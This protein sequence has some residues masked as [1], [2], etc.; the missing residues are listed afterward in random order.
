[1]STRESAHPLAEHARQNRTAPPR[2]HRRN[3]ARRAVVGGAL[4]LALAGVGAA[5]GFTTGKAGF[6]VRVRDEVID[7]R[8]FGIYVMP[9]EVV[10]LEVVA[11]PDPA[12]DYLLDAPQGELLAAS[13]TG[14]SWRAPRTPGLY[15]LA[16]AAPGTGGTMQLQVFVLVPATQMRGELLNGYRIGRYPEQPL[17]GLA[18]YLPPR[19]FVEVTAANAATPLAPHF[20]LGQF[21]C[22]QAGGYPKYVVLRERLL[23]KLELLLE[24]ANERGHRAGSF[25]VMSGYRTPFY[26]HAIHNVRYSR[27][28]YGDAADIFID[29]R[30]HDG[31]MDDLNGDGLVSFRDADVLRDLVEEMTVRP[32]YAPF[33]GGLGRYRKNAAH[34]PFVHVDARGYRARWEG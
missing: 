4:L 2:T 1:M 5:Q 14:W 29:E 10:D 11:P 13:A 22:K 20:T 15:P 18:S 21:V 31:M 17:R 19:G 9:G 16:L 23:A 26:N 27:H 28:I 6:A 34:G 3:A 24:R 33:V 12:G 32:W 30:P 25:H 8:T 7:Y